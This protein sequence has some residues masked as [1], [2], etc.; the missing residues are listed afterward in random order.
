MIYHILKWFDISAISLIFPKCSIEQKIKKDVYRIDANGVRT[1][2]YS[3][4]GWIQLQKP[5]AC[6][7]FKP[8]QN[9]K[10]T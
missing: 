6:Q 10:S 1:L 7:C 3:I 4:D 9:E 8:E 2:K 5:I